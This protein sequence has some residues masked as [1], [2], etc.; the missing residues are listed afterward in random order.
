MVSPGRGVDRMN[1]PIPYADLGV[2]LRPVAGSLPAR[3]AQVS[4]E[5][6]VGLCHAVRNDGGRLLTLWGAD[7][8]DQQRGFALHVVLQDSEGLLVVLM[9][10]SAAEPCYPDLSAIFPCAD[11]LQRA[12]YDLLGIRATCGDQRPWL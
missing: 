1:A 12:T 10:L 11:R 4:A 2:S 7:D 6:L 8:R 3:T 5:Q 9:R